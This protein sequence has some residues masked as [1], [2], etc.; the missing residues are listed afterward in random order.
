M[1]VPCPAARMMILSFINKKCPYLKA[2][3]M[4]KN[5]GKVDQSH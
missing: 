5:V 1:R 2:M 3:I 4:Q